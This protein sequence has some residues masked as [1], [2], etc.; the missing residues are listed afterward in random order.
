MDSESATIK[1]TA[2]AIL[3]MIPPT[4]INQTYQGLDWFWLTINNMIPIIVIIRPI[5]NKTR[6]EIPMG[7]VSPDAIY[8]GKG[9]KNKN[10]FVKANRKMFLWQK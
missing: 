4:N 3:N 2:P 5:S 1:R 7:E 8:F 9:I 10:V 6:P